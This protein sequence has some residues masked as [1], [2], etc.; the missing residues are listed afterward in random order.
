MELRQLRYFIAVAEYLSFSKAAEELHI[1]VPP[2][3]RQIRQLEEEFD[4]QLFVRNR[5]RVILSDA[6]RLFLREA[7]TLTDQMVNFTNC[8]RRAAHG[9]AG[10]VRIGIGLHLGERLSRAVVEHSKQYP[11]VELQTSGIFPALQ[12]A[13]LVE[14]KIDVGFLRP[15][16][17]HMHLKSEI[18]FDERLAALVNRTNPL[19]KRKSLRAKD[20]VGETILLQ[21]RRF[22][23]GLH[24]KILEVFARA[25]VS[26]HIVELPADPL[27]NDDV[28]TVLLAANRG[29]YIT[30]DEAPARI[31]LGRAAV[32]VPI[33]EPGASVQVHMVWRKEEASATVL[34][35]LASLR[36]VFGATQPARP[37]PFMV[38]SSGESP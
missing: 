1:T 4:V 12:N 18:L 33:D 38:A 7:K 22:S 10:A 31:T 9:D 6:G 30:A 37:A 25:G 32:A 26:P 27:P 29:I 23:P 13:A 8:V 14:G 2:L 15:P 28:Q 19:A 16:I 21:D 35:F 11:L 17:D 3:S 5:R 20:L 36:R 34:A 24:D